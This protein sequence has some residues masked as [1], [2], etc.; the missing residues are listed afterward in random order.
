MKKA[1]TK[2]QGEAKR[3]AS[4]CAHCN[5]NRSYDAVARTAVDLASSNGN[6]SK[7]PGVGEAYVDVFHKW[8][9][10]LDLKS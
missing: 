4:Q 3:S 10:N 2:Q 8:A 1:R 9:A 5:F 6:L 7:M